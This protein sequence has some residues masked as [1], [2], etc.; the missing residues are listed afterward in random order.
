MVYLFFFPFCRFPF[1]IATS[2]VHQPH[3]QGSCFLSKSSI[4]NGLQTFPLFL[5]LSFFFFPL[6]SFF[7]FLQSSCLCV[8]VCYILQTLNI[9]FVTFLCS[10]SFSFFFF[11]PFFFRLCQL[12][13]RLH[14][15]DNAHYFADIE[16]LTI[17]FY[18]IPPFNTLS[19]QLGIAPRDTSK[20]HVPPS[21]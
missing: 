9:K 4:L 8:T 20:D 1:F 12:L 18:I 21:C 6:L 15:L 5:C 14:F 7:F 19:W 3:I 10:F 2:L 17:L 16:K 13:W 11:E